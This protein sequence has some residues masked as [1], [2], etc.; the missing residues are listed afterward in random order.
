VNPLSL[1]G[2]CSIEIFNDMWPTMAKV[3]EA[4]RV[5]KNAH[6][7][8]ELPLGFRAHDEGHLES[9][10]DAVFGMPLE[11]VRGPEVAKSDRFVE[12]RAVRR[13]VAQERRLLMRDFRK[14]QS[15]LSPVNARAAEWFF[16][17]HTHE[18]D[19]FPLPRAALREELSGGRLRYYEGG[20]GYLAKDPVYRS[21]ATNLS[22]KAL[23]RK[24]RQSSRWFLTHVLKGTP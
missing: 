10:D 1:A 22:K 20:A 11:K 17:A 14:E 23:N 19:T 16:F 3:V 6:G 18:I 2:L 12:L 8:R 24:M 7:Q 21:L 4:P 9:D 15:K 13:R 5:R